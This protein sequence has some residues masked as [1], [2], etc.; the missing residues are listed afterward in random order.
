MD[1]NLTDETSYTIQYQKACPKYIENEYRSKHRGFPGTKSK[2]IPNNNLILY[3]MPSTSDQSSADQYHLSRDDEEY[4]MPDNVAEL[5][6]RRSD[7]AVCLL[8]ATG[9]SFNSPPQ[10]HQNSG[11][12]YPNLDDSYSNQME[13]SSTFWLPDIAA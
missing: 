4:I 11:Q 2:S 13:N 12:I 1:S 5:T 10:L 6:P 3:T 7:C 9:L 8:R